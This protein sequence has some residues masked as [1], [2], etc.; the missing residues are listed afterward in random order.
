MEA[1]VWRACAGSLIHIPMVNSR[2][3][4]FPQGHTEQSSDPVTF[5][6]RV[7]S[8]PC[9]PCRVRK[10]S[11]HADPDT[12]EVFA[13]FSL[14]PNLVDGSGSSADGDAGRGDGARGDGFVSFT[15]ILT[16]SDSNNGGGFSVPRFC[17]DSVYPPLN[18]EEETPVQSIR[19][20]D[21]HGREWQ[22]RHIYRGT[23]RRHLLTTG[24]SKFV[25]NKKLIAGDS[26]V[27]IRKVLT[28]ELFVGIRRAFK[29]PLRPTGAS[30]AWALPRPDRGGAAGGRGGGRGGFSRTRRG[31]VPSEAVV[32]AA[33]RA[34]TGQ[35]FEA[36]YYPK[37][38]M[39]EFVV[40]ADKVETS[41]ALYWTSGIRVKMA[42]ETDV[43][44][45]LTWYNGTVTSAVPAP[46][47]G[48]WYGSTWRMLQVAWDESEVLESMKQVSPWQVEYVAPMPD[49][50]NAFP[51]AKKM[52]AVQDS[53]ILIQGQGDLP[54]PP[55]GLGPMMGQSFLEYNNFPAGM[56]GARQNPLFQ[57]SL[58]LVMGESSFQVRPDNNVNNLGSSPCETPS[59]S[60]QNCMPCFGS[61]ATEQ[62]SFNLTRKD[63]SSFQLFGKII[64]LEK[65][66]TNTDDNR[67]SEIDPRN[68]LGNSSLVPGQMLA[69]L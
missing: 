41:W 35:Q 42:L 27:F 69:D 12:D 23:P 56:Q 14:Q 10:I 9:V 8:R 11:F 47:H 51:S 50:H 57:S 1:G 43:G 64:L 13:K 6:S 38:G 60:S 3:Y 62:R 53:G 15:K 33:E 34:V 45:R 24:W 46:N 25:N 66:Q 19:M 36:V 20:T 18:F 37:P 26:V 28:G 55:I 22:F 29:K 58:P 40:A 48:P 44:S 4:Y 67:D 7:T 5:S 61:A 32:E 49:I 68:I 65:P 31:R 17:A 54:L 2:V 16:Q 30:S 52:K 39:P 59:T 21:V 63:V